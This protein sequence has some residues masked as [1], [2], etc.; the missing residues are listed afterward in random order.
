MNAAQI[1]AS[2]APDALVCV[3][4]RRTRK[5][6]YQD[7]SAAY[8]LDWDVRIITEAKGDLIYK[9]QL[10]GKIPFSK[11]GLGSV[12]AEPE[13][14]VLLQHLVYLT[15]LS[16]NTEAVRSVVK[17]LYTP[18]YDD[19]TYGVNG[20]AMSA[21]GTLL[22]AASEAGAV[23]W[24]RQS[25]D[26]LS[27]IKPRLGEPYAVALSPDNRLLALSTTAYEK[28]LGLYE[29]RSGKVI[30]KIDLGTDPATVESLQFLDQGS[31]LLGASNSGVYRWDT[32]TGKQ[33]GFVPSSRE[34]GVFAQDV[35]VAPGGKLY[36]AAFD[37]GSVTV[38][39]TDG[40]GEVSRVKVVTSV[41]FG[42][43]LSSRGDYAVSR[44]PGVRLF[45]Q[46]SATGASLQ[47]QDSYHMLFAPD[48]EQLAVYSESQ[49]FVYQVATL[50]R[51]VAFPAF[52][53]GA[54]AFSADGKF[55]IYGGDD[56]AVRIVQVR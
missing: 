5:G 46:G 29:V 54:L 19:T 1:P 33:T 45:P 9:L 22:A 6:E 39:R 40:S 48:G 15:S 24:D 49:I 55:L 47:D 14:E 37:N 44:Q 10:P 13:F 23:V 4:Q 18:K 7:G 43:A 52:Q 21:D 35:S 36:A 3:N 27:V 17:G 31:V 38:C 2:N 53:A 26:A 51:L 28:T 50:K 56:G 34:K 41:V 11:Q 42:A 12:T 8:G 30:H 25:G 16:K 32:G 20:V